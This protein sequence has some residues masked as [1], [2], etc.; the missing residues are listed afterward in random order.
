MAWA[1]CLDYGCV[2]DLDNGRGFWGFYGHRMQDSPRS[3]DNGCVGAFVNTWSIAHCN[4]SGT[5]V[6]KRFSIKGFPLGNA[7]E[8]DQ[9]P[10]SGNYGGDII[11]MNR[12]SNIPTSVL[13]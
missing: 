5:P 2:A 12:T 4:R 11:V 1:S 7:I 3:L 9:Q 10:N 8:I 6:H 13:R